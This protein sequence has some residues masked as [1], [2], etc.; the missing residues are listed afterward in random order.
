MYI[1][2]VFE[3][4]FRCVSPPRA[5]KEPKGLNDRLVNAKEAFLEQVRAQIALGVERWKADA[6]TLAYGTTIDQT[7]MTHRV[8]PI[9]FRSVKPHDSQVQWV[10]ES[11]GDAAETRLQASKGAI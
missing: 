4:G 10:G 1:L 3:D 2:F 6:M 9:S 8:T 5:V 11:P 7:F